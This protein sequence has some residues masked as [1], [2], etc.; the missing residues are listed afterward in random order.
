MTI[1]QDEVARITDT[2]SA[3]RDELRELGRS[4]RK[5]VSRSGHA[6][7][8]APCVA[9]ATRWRS[10]PSPTPAA[11]PIWFPSGTGA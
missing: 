5:E 6:G 8:T 3:T 11:Y 9:A 1:V 7:W 4:L 2:G 10:S